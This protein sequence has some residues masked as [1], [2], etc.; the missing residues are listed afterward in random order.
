M[1]LLSTKA[2]E[3]CVA[4]N[5]SKLE[6]KD[7]GESTRE[8]HSIACLLLDSVSH[9]QCREISPTFVHAFIGWLST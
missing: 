1:E 3:R 5:R 7:F 9:P 2:G 8:R 6:Y 4:A